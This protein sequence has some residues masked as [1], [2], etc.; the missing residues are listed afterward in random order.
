MAFCWPQSHRRYSE[1]DDYL[2][3]TSLLNNSFCNHGMLHMCF[4]FSGWQGSEGS[5]SHKVRMRL[6]KAPIADWNN[7]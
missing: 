4:P 7:K 6:S 3:L 2:G 1:C 5:D